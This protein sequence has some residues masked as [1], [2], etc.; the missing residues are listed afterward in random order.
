[1][2][3]TGHS[4]LGSQK[5][6]L[7]QLADLAW[8]VPPVGTA[9]RH[10][11]ELMFRESGLDCPNRLVETASPMVV[12]KLLG[13]SDFVALLPCDVAEYYAG[14][15]LVRELPIGLPCNMDPFGVITRKGWLLSP[16]AQLVSETLE[17]A[18]VH[19]RRIR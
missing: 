5:L 1:V 16:A 8:I 9:L 13:E 6:E 2:A 4:L 15:G 18:V 10:R 3:R 7:S 19:T 17:D 14:C 12:T 11:F